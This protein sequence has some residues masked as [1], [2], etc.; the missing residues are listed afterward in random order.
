VLAPSFDFPEKAKKAPRL[1]VVPAEPIAD[2][3]IGTMTAMVYEANTRR[4]GAEY[5]LLADLRYGGRQAVAPDLAN[6][7]IADA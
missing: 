2:P 7:L 4:G 1:G 3:P 6:Q 5:R